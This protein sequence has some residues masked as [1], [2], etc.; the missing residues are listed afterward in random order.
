MIVPI[1]CQRSDHWSLAQQ[2]AERFDLPI[3]ES[4][5]SDGYYLQFS[6]EGLG[7][8]AADSRQKPLHL[9]WE[10]DLTNLRRRQAEGR[11]QPLGRAV[12]LKA[13]KPLPK[14]LDL[15]AGLGRDGL[16]L[17]SLG[18]CMTLV[19]RSP[20]VAALL[21]DAQRRALDVDEL[22]S[23]LQNLNLQYAD[24]SAVLRQL[25]PP[26]PDVLYLDPMYPV[27][28]KSAAVKKAMQ[29]FHAVVGKDE[30]AEQLLYQAREIGIPRIVVKR[31]K[32]A[33]P[34]GDLAA[35]A[36]IKSENTRYDVYLQS[37]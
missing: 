26:L 11:R 1:C 16:V 20:I 13:G 21:F 34:L 2:F 32:A 28:K 37:R 22:Q 4:I 6:D 36:V 19:E 35:D 18:C 31:P 27:R 24:G 33:Q 3:Q 30:D 29:F 9:D 23:L 17:A 7:L 10:Q 14:V 12:G 5:P 15:T 25:S 8:Y